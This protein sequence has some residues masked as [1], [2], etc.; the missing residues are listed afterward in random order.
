[1]TTSAASTWEAEIDAWA[2]RL[3]AAGRR[4]GTIGLRSAHVRMLAGW[5]NRERVGAGPWELTTEDLEAWAGSKAWAPSTRRSVRATLRGFYTW[6]VVAKRIVENPATDL[7]SIPVQRPRPRPCDPKVLR[8]AVAAADP[9]EVLMIRLAAE[10][11]MRRGEIAQVHTRDLM[12]DL[13]NWSLLVHGKGGKLRVIPLPEMLAGELA[14]RAR[15]EPGYLFPGKIDGHLSAAWVGRLVSRWLDEYTMH[16]LRH[17]FA[18]HTH[19]RTKNL[20]AVQQQLGHASPATTKDYI[21]VPMDDMRELVEIAADEL[22]G[23]GRPRPKPRI[24]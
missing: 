3:R 20:L 10:C 12:P 16:T 13:L 22:L 15:D 4:P 14:R 11:G 6:G 9:R 1:M 7:P 21:E 23:N 5:A 2:T 17:L 24:A 8:A 18:T 19:N